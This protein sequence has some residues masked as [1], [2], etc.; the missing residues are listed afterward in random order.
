MSTANPAKAIGEANRLGSL[1]VDRQADTSV[2]DLRGG[3]SSS[4]TTCWARACVSSR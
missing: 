4:S 2:L 3:D 1:P